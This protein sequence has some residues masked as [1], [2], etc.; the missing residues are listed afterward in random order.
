MSPIAQRFLFKVSTRACSVCGLNS[1]VQ[2]VM[3]KY[4]LVFVLA[5]AAC[6]GDS[7]TPTASGVF[8]AEGFTGRQLRVEISG[9]ATTWKDGATVDFGTGVTVNSVDVASPTDLFANITI[10]P[11]AAP[12]KNDV[13]V[14]SGSKKYTLAKAFEL[15][16]PIAVTFSG[17]VAQFGVPNFTISN[18]D[19]ESPFDITQDQA[20]GAYPNLVITS[21]SGTEFIISAATQYQLSGQVFIDG[22]GM[23]GPVSLVSGPQGGTTN[24]TSVG[25]AMTV[26]PRTPT[27]FSGSA[28]GNFAAVGDSAVYGV[29]ASGNSLLH[30]KLTA[31]DQNASPASAILGAGGTWR[32]DFIGAGY[33]L[34]SGSATIVVVNLGGMGY[35]YT[36]TGAVEAVTSAAEGTDATNGTLAGALVAT[37]L[38]F[39]QTGGKMTSTTDQD[40]IKV[41]VDAAHAN[42]SLHVVT[43]QGTDVSTD[44][45]VEVTNCQTG[46][47]KVSY[48]N[49]VVDGSLCGIFG[50]APGD[51]L[52]EDALSSPLAA[53]TY[54]VEISAGAAWASADQ[55]YTAVIWFE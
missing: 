23:S 40:W 50:C 8:P 37:A 54:C 18:L 48:T 6:G 2:I 39:E 24:V 28:T 38:P 22:N 14:T 45:A 34:L 16:S 51:N 10:D 41:T 5:A 25:S 46:G 31:S 30:Y 9:D 4:S 35:T 17:D 13:T 36:L 27:P 19:F 7:T 53:G 11:M 12:G 42:K 52:G 29:T 47:A 43:N 15:V 3:H 1:E 32:N 33:A 21:P 55:N 26:M 49:G 20:T 44:T